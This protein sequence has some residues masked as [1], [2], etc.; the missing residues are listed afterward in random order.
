[1]KKNALL[2]LVTILILGLALSACER[3][4]T[5]GPVVTPTVKGE[6]PFPVATQP[7]IVKDYLA[8]TQTAQAG[9]PSAGATSTSALPFPTSAATATQGILSTPVPTA[10]RA[11]LPSPTPGRPSTYSLQDG[12]TIY[13]L[14]RRYDVDPADLLSLNNLTLATAGMLSIGTELKIPQSGSYPGDR[15]FH[16][17]PDTY[18]VDPGDTISRIACYYGDLSPDAILAYNGLKAGTTLSVGQAL[19]I[20]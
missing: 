18:T 16:A 5:R 13:C 12:E 9:N 1:M 3:P 7:Q 11:V 6:I 14:A 19:Q 2:L 20:P 15:V 17:H 4:A 8:I 10:T